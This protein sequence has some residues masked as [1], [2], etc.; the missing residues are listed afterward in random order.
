MLFQ[1]SPKK[2]WSHWRT[3]AKKIG[4]EKRS[5]ARRNWNFFQDSDGINENQDFPEDEIDQ[6]GDDCI[7]NPINDIIQNN[8]L[9][10]E[11]PVENSQKR[12]ISNETPVIELLMAG[13]SYLIK[14]SK[15]ILVDTGY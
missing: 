1:I 2:V 5:I 10:D 13:I 15:K 7:E 9:L 14:L 8:Q 3:R 12:P 11:K 4:T 6:S